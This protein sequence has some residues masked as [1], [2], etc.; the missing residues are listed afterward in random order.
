MWEK[1]EEKKRKLKLE[2]WLTTARGL[3]MNKKSSTEIC[4]STGFKRIKM[5]IVF[6]IP[7]GQIWLNNKSIFI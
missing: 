4:Q 2:A 7:S 3:K 1:A 6:Q 5:F